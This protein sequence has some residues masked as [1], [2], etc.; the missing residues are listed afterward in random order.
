MSEAEVI[1]RAVSIDSGVSN[2]AIQAGK[3]KNQEDMER[4]RESF[5]KV[6]NS[7]LFMH[8]PRLGTTDEIYHIIDDYRNRYGITGVVWDFIQ[9][10]KPSP[11]QRGQSREQ[12]I[13]DAS[14][15]MVDDVA[16]GMGIVSIAL[17]QQNRD[18][19]AKRSLEGVGGSYQISQ[20]ADDMILIERLNKQEKKSEKEKQAGANRVVI[21][22]KRRGGP[23]NLQFNVRLE[24]DNPDSLRFNELTNHHDWM[25]IMQRAA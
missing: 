17:S 18:R 19:D 11:D 14:K 13:G 20:D 1:L 6:H 12:I 8:K 2:T 10:V 16:G 25:L 5:R 15:M 7:Q 3:F 9:K 21:V 24:L 22:T 23:A 4:V